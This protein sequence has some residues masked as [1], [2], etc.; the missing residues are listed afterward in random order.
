M[1]RYPADDLRGAGGA[2]QPFW[3]HAQI[4]GTA[5]D[6]V[7][8][9]ARALATRWVADD[10]A[11]RFVHS[12]ATAA[13]TVV[14]EGVGT[15]DLWEEPGRLVC[16]FA[17]S[18]SPDVTAPRPDSRRLRLLTWTTTPGGPEPGS[19]IVVE[20]NPVRVTLFLPGP[21]C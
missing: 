15:F 6:V 17:N 10:L 5:L 11:D 4:D 18:G 8:A 20:H 21:F 16:H 12:V 9:L 19:G 13:A 14:S 2:H 1:P 3:A 7:T